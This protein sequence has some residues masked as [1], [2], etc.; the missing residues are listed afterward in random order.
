ML[1]EP[2]APPAGMAAAYAGLTVAAVADALDRLGY[3]GQC[4]GLARHGA[5]ARFCGRVFTVQIM[6]VGPPD[7]RLPDGDLGEYIEDVPEGYVVAIDHRGRTDACVWD[8]RLTARARARGVAGVVVD[9]ACRGVS[10]EDGLA[11]WARA[12]Q[13]RHGRRRVRVEACNL[14]VV[15]GGVRVECDD[16]MLADADGVV[17]VPRDHLAAVLE[18]ARQGAPTRTA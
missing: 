13:P 6:P 5:M 17:V 18:M 11:V 3:A 7:G 10:P 15:V 12:V 1:K 16:L 4:A 2:S 8:E 9:G 14:P